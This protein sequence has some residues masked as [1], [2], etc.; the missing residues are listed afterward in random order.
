MNKLNRFKTPLVLATVLA[1][2]I[3]ANCSA[4]EDAQGAVCCT[5][6]KAGG[7]VSASIGG[8]AQAQVA[9]QAV[10]DFSGI[11]AAAIDDITTAC[12]N[13]ATDLDGDKTKANAAEQMADKK[14]KM[15]AWCELAVASIG[16]FKATAGGTL[17]LVVNPPMCNVSV[18]AKANCQAKCSGS[19]SCDVKANPPVCTGGKLE[20][21]CK[22]GCTGEAGASVKC[23]GGCSGSCTGSCTAMGGVQCAGT[24]EGA[25]EGNTQNG[26]AT[27]K[28]EGMCKGTCSATAPSVKCEGSC[29][30]SCDAKCEA[31]A[32]ATIKCDGKCD[33]DFEPLK[34][35]GG[36]LEGGCKADVKCDGNCDASVSAKAECTPPSISVQF[37]GEADVNAAGR[38]QA[39]FEAN[40]PLIFAFK[41]RLEGMAKLTATITG[42]ADVVVDIKAACIPA[43]IASAVAAGEDVTASV[44]VTTSLVGAV[45]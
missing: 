42:N 37:T 6:Y 43:V 8:G 18:S 9:V 20:I 19:A 17:A 7:T 44:S 12:R 24:C 23:E 3:L 40:L 1:L 29:Q 21:S 4:V 38:I 15:K 36:K 5:E 10:S 22:G 39:T 25:C 30:G 14:D 31:K 16:T 13:I 26:A 33:G 32:G 35:E 27:G 41:A 28:C 34:C 45:Q 11:A 2:P